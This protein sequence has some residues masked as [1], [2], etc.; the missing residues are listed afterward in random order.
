M[1]GNLSLYDNLVILIYFSVV[2]VIG[3][4]AS[5]GKDKTAKDYFLGGREMSWFVIGM[6]LFATNISA[7][8]L[9]GL[10]GSGSIHGLSVGYFGW[11]ATIILILLGWVFA[12]IFI[13]SNVY[14]VPEFFGKRFDGRTRTYLTIVSISSYFLLKIGVTLLAAGYILSRIIGLDMFF[15]SILLVLLT[16]IYTVIG[17]LNSVMKTQIFQAFMI[18]LGAFL[19]TVFGLEEIGGISQL[20]STLPD[21]YFA[22]FKSFSDPDLPWTGIFF[23]API[24]GIWYWCTDQ[25]IVQRILSAKGIE[26]AKKGTAL[27]ALLKTVPILLFILPGMIA[28]EIFPSIS[29]DEV[30]PYLIGSDILPSGIKGIVIAGL[31]A[32]L[33]SSLASAFNSAATLVANDLYKPRNLKLLDSELVLVGRLSTTIIVFLTIAAIPLIRMVNTQIYIYLQVLQAYISP[34]IAS[35]FLIGIFWK[36]ATSDAAF[37]SLIVGGVLGLI[38]IVITF[39]D[40]SIINNFT[41]LK[42]INDWNYMHFAIFLFVTSSALMFLISFYGSKR[43]KVFVKRN[44]VMFEKTDLKLSFSSQKEEQ[45]EIINQSKQTLNV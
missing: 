38:R 12:P 14:T 10:A 34:P 20:A 39:L 15:S 44:D 17:G 31:F 43:Y 8:H 19:L 41:V 24:L 22:I 36:K 27:A 7:E 5:I 21:K 33:M 29:G 23:G 11:F 4:A 42:L 32:A 13:K 1:I 18:L 2:M 16:G 37:W 3:I 40:N 35:V 30:Y 6:S 9:V 25:Y 45:Y 28:L 26:A